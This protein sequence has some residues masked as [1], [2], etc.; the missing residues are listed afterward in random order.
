MFSFITLLQQYSEKTV[1]RPINI[2]NV[3]LNKNFFKRPE[4]YNMHLPTFFCVP[5]VNKKHFFS[6]LDD[7]E[8]PQ[9]YRMLSTIDEFKSNSSSIN[10]NRV[11]INYL[12][13]TR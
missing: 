10:R 7:V 9:W 1:V 5:I 13:K 8:S 12:R 4:K 2:K 11:A 6:Y 3:L